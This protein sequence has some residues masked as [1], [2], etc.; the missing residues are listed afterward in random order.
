VLLHITCLQQSVVACYL[1]TDLQEMHGDELHLWLT[2]LKSWNIRRLF[3]LR[4]PKKVSSYLPE[5]F[6]FGYI[7]VQLCLRFY[8]RASV[9]RAEWKLWCKLYCGQKYLIV[10]YSLRLLAPLKR[11]NVTTALLEMI[12][13]VLVWVIYSVV[14]WY[15]CS[16]I[17]EPVP[18]III[19]RHITLISFAIPFL[20]S[21]RFQAVWLWL[22]F[23]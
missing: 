8:V 7:N 15:S 12:N 11:S 21:P 10:F 1:F 18:E 17:S 13:C 14:A 6:Y 20:F 5:L 4:D 23:S 22:I 2:F 19:R 9:W 16:N 3:W